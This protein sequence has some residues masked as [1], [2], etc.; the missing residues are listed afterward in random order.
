MEDVRK[1]DILEKGE[2]NARNNV[3]KKKL[4]KSYEENIDMNLGKM[5]NARNM[6]G[7]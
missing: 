5:G 7:S 4:G 3:R 2:K 1:K 6:D